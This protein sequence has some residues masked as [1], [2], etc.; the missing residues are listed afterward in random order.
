MA[1]PPY[2]RHRAGII[3]V[4]GRKEDIL[5][6]LNKSEKALLPAL[7]CLWNYMGAG[8]KIP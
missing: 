8:P 6:N 5:A 4:D 3:L 1:H 2:T 7:W